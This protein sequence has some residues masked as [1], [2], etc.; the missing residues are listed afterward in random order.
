[1]ARRRVAARA[2]GSLPG[3]ALHVTAARAEALLKERER[4]LRDV[5]KKKRQLEQARATAE[6]EAQAEAVKMAPLV[7]RHGALARELAALFDELLAEGRLSTRARKQVLKLRRSLELQG[8]LSPEAGIDEDDAEVDAGWSDDEPG[9]PWSEQPAGRRTSGGK[10][11]AGGPSRG[12]GAPESSV[13]DVASAPQPGHERRTLRDIFRSLARAVHPDQARQE[14]ERARRTEVM[15]ELTRA[16]EAGDLARLLELESAWQSERALAGDGDP[17]AR[18]RE[19]ERVNRELLNQSRQL[20][21][22]LRDVK[23][24]ARAASFGPLDYLV[25]R[26]GHELDDF[27]SICELVRRFRDGKLTLAELMLGLAHLQEDD[28]DDD[29]WF[30]LEDLLSAELDDEPAP[31]QP[32]R[33]GKGPRRR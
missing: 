20:T 31:P 24:D 22:Q 17:E 16:Y 12:S 33:G 10:G 13:R 8:Y 30:V 26:A 19:L 2:Q 28:D 1:M 32:R 5:N 25:E 23:R 4:L 6:Q 7:E 27:A 3:L 29:I 21:R 18:C 15:K 14:P 9:A 11:R